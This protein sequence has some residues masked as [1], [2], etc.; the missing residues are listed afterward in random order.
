MD[1]EKLIP[2]D[3][4]VLYRWVSLLSLGLTQFLVAWVAVF[5]VAALLYHNPPEESINFTLLITPQA[6]SLLSAVCVTYTLG[7]LT[8]ARVIFS[9]GEP[10]S[11][12]LL[13]LA[14]LKLNVSY[15]TLTIAVVSFVVNILLG[16]YA[17]G[18]CL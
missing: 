14:V 2:Y 12:G 18:K 9:K 10:A 13:S 6:L 11:S 7:D 8:R 1:D 4:D 17:G 15:I 3:D 16:N 5:C